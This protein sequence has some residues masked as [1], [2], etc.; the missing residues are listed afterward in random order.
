M[1]IR[2]G[3]IHFSFGQAATILARDIL[4]IGILGGIA[5]IITFIFWKE[6]KLLVFDE[7]FAAS[8]WVP[9]PHT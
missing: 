6:L 7:G 9:N 3:W 4:T 8:A 5:I 2:R 1:R